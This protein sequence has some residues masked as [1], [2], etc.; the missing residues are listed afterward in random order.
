MS[1][2][3]ETVL[4]TAHTTTGGR[5]GQG[6]SDDNCGDTDFR[7]LRGRAN[8]YQMNS[9]KKGPYNTILDTER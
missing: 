8:L 1:A 3:L 9:H 6:V 5:D 2:K 7:R 4:Y